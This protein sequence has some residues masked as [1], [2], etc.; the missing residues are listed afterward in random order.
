MISADL[1]ARIDETRAHLTRAGVRVSYASLTEI[2]LEEL[3]S[4]KDLAAILRRHR[5]SLKRR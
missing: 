3:L 2:A 4:Q 5:A 1:H